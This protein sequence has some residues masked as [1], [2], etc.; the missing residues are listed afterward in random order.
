MVDTCVLLFCAVP[1]AG[2]VKIRLGEVLG[3]EVTADLYRLFV[4]DLLHGLEGVEADVR[5]HYLPVGDTPE[6]DMAAWLGNDRRCIPQEGI[7]K[8]ERM[9]RAMSQAFADGYTRVVLLHCDVP[10]FP[11][12]L[13]QKTLLD[14]DMKD[15]AI[16]PAYD[17]GYYLIGF[18]RD[19][20]FPEVFDHI[21]W[22]E[23]E[24]FRP[25]MD[26]LRERGLEV[27]RLPDWNVVDTIWDVNVL[28]RTNRNSSFRKS[29][30]F[31]VLREHAEL[32]RQYDLDLPKLAECAI[33]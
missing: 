24:I 13:V 8:G 16:G 4:E 28:L 27:L 5:V 7:D 23:A 15:V 18:R 26:R 17:G 11:P 29:S 19:A 22:G 3:H 21:A 14:L 33:C 9:S 32:I 31:A 6:Q 10:D 1:K 20:F 12:E 25:T 30:T 2:R